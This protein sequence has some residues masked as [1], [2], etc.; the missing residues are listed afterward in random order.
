MVKPIIQRAMEDGL[1]TNF[2]SIRDYMYKSKTPP[3]IKYSG[4]YV[5]FNKHKNL[6]YGQHNDGWCEVANNKMELLGVI[7]YYKK[8]KKFVWEQCP[9]IIMAEDCLW[10]VNE[11]IQILNKEKK[12]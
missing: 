3:K 4:S 10:K 1:V 5:I 2:K 12:S 9:E 11:I 6:Y 7:Y 8:W